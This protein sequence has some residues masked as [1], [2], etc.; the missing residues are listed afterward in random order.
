MTKEAIIIGAGGHGKV[1]SSIISANNLQISGYFDDAFS[2]SGNQIQ[3]KPL[4]GMIKEIEHLNPERYDL[5]LAIGNNIL[6]E[7]YYHHFKQ[8]GFHFPKLV[9]PLANVEKDVSIDEA[10]VICIGATICTEARIGVGCIINT[11]ASVDHESYVGNFSH[12]AP[13]AG[14][15]G[16]VQVGKRT[17]IC[18]GA[19]I[20]QTLTIGDDVTIGA[21]S[22]VLKPVP[23][24]SKIL[25][26]YH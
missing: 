4:L 10:S 18:M 5:Y 23:N 19:V 26:V 13:Q 25:G 21:N 17:F 8:F 1:V 6:R 20:A 2:G 12:I 22:V 9:H 15:A 3:Q 11:N 24:N 14:L 16:R 7:Q